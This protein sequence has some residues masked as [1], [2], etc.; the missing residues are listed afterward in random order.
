[1]TQ[2]HETTEQDLQ[3]FK[4]H[5]LYWIRR[6]ELNDWAFGWRMEELDKSNARVTIHSGSRK[7]L[8]RLNTTLELQ[9]EPLNNLALHECLEVML[10]DLTLYLGSFMSNSVVED[11][12]HRVINRLMAVL[13]VTD[14]R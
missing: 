11:E 5:C 3:E 10:G 8:F 14:D 12:T 9:Y 6:L 2:D 1:M 13:L 4:D 7:A